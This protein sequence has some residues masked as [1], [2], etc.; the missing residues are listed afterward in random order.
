[1]ASSKTSLRAQVSTALALLL[2][3]MV[4]MGVLAP[5]ASA[6]TGGYPYASLNGPGTNAPGSFWADNNGNGVSPNGYNYRNCT[7]YVAWRLKS[8]NVADSKVRGLGNG[9]EW[10]SKA[11]GRTGVTVGNVPSV[12]SAAIKL[13]SPGDSWG[14]VAFVESV[15]NNGTI[16]VSEYNWVVG[17]V[18]DGAYH[19][20]TGTP[21][22]LG[23]TKFVN[24]GV[25]IVP[26]DE[27][28]AALPM[29][30]QPDAFSDLAILHQTGDM[31]FD[32][33]VLYGSAGTPF[34]HNPTF[35]R[36]FAE[37]NGWE[38]GK[39]KTSS[40]DYNGDGLSDI[41]V[42]H[43]LNDGGAAA[44]VH[45]LWGGSGTPFTHA[46]TLVRHL[47]AAAGWD[48]SKMTLASGRF[49]ADNFSDLAIL[50][51]TSDGGF[52]T[53]ILYGSAGTPFQHNPTFTRHFAGVDGW[54]WSK[55]KTSAGDYNSDNFTDIAVAHQLSDGG[56]DIRVLWGGSGIPFTFPETFVRNLPASAGWDWS[57][58]ILASGKF[59]ADAFSDLAILHQTGDGGF[60]AHVLYG[61]TGTP[62]QHNPT[63]VQHY[64]GAAGWDWSKIKAASSDYNGDSFT[65]IAVAHQLGD[66]GADIRVL[67]GGSG[68]PFANTNTL[69]RNLPASAGWEWAK[70]RLEGS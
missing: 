16:T 68:I 1:M 41:A 33:H 23:L 36:H 35:A 20:R 57:K 24:F 62:F 10:A 28:Q 48:W 43:Q 25:T 15:N 12:A 49:Q 29:S 70:M 11:Q 46:S 6:E 13:S 55:I 47:P 58:M 3:L 37:S 52:D 65:D 45:V 39:I 59:Q 69:V 66:G 8:L 17:G 51:Q 5:V 22:A 42:V 14:H 30:F 61:S 26:E 60:D 67:W 7:D 54:D 38:W 56:A 31:G 44:D 64:P 19:M 18:P 63:L 2:T 40:G 27:P 34:Q 4:G 50:H 21:A 53:H 9:G 32:A